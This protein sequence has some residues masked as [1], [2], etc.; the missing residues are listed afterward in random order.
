MTKLYCDVNEYDKLY[1]NKLVCDKGVRQT[2]VCVCDKVVCHKVVCDK[3]VCD[4]KLC[5][6]KL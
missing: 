4:K 3:V 5:V 1:V 2:V 6:T